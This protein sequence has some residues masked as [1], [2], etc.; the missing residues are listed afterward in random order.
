M[1]YSLRLWFKN[2]QGLQSPTIFSK[3]ARAFYPIS[4]VILVTILS[5]VWIEEDFLYIR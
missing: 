3:K 5:V 1:L 2:W 4:L